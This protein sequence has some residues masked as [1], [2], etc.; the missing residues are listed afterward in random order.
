MQLHH[1][2]AVDMAMEIYRKTEDEEIRMMAYDMATAQSAQIGEMY[3][4]LVNWGLPQRGDP[5][6][7]AVINVLLSNRPDRRFHRLYSFHRPGRSEGE[8]R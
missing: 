1:A 3:S 5:L 8:R 7:N 6:M 4:W 2:Q